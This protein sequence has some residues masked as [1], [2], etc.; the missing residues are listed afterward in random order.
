MTPQNKVTFFVIIGLSIL[1]VAV[2]FILEVSGIYTLPTRQTMQARIE[3]AG[4]TALEAWL[5]TAAQAFNQRDQNFQVMIIP[6]NGSEA[7]RRLNASVPD[8]PDVWI[9]EAD[10][11][12]ARLSDPP[13]ATTGPSIAQDYLLWVAVNRRAELTDH[14]D[15]Q[16]VQELTVTDWQFKVALPPP[17]HLVGLAACLSA[18]AT[19]HQEP[20]L[21]RNLVNDAGFRQ[22]LEQLFEA[23]P[24]RR[25]NPRDQLISRP[26]KVDV[27]LLLQ[28]ETTAFNSTDFNHQPPTY[29]VAFNHPY[30]IRTNWLDL[31][32]DEIEARQFVAEQFR[33]FLLSDSQQTRLVDYHLKPANTPLTGQPVQADELT[34][35]SLQ[36]C[37]Q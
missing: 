14:L 20:T 24:N 21:N 33:Q 11:A 5:Q 12:R 27:G 18:A 37:W 6:V 10:F 15:W 32:P 19:Y 13:Y 28:S 22:W 36:W 31:P 9:A 25:Q 1:V 29:N 16:P 8:L 35:R 2:F 30:L 3:V 26:P 7:S 17:N 4:P 34:M 23:I